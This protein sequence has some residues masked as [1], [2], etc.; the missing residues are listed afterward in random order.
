M[1]KRL[2]LSASLAFLVLL[3]IPAL[4]GFSGTDLILPAAGR[5]LG[6]G[7]S[8]FLTTGWVTNPNAEAV[9]VQFQFLEAGQANPN[10]VTVTDTLSPGQTKTYENLAE[11][12]FNRVGVLGAVRV[13]SS[14]RIL[15]S[16]R[17][18]SQAPGA[19]L[20]DTN[21]VY[22]AAVPSSFAIGQDELG[23]LQGVTNNDDF[24]YN[25]FVVEVSG[26][27]T[28]LEVRLRD[29]A[30]AELAT[31]TYPLRPW[32]QMLVST[33]DLA[34]GIM[35]D[36]GRIDATVVSDQGRAI[37]AGS[38]VANGSQD[39]TGFEM[40]FKS[41][42]LAENSQRVISLNGLSGV[43]SADGQFRRHDHTIGQQHQYRCDGCGRA[44]GT[45]GANGTEGLAGSRRT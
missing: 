10:P 41:D 43:V 39:S 24:R 29:G 13:R 22:F 8:E 33:S 42:L 12:L 20:A 1:R 5:V 25:F 7:G 18:Y 19:M 23:S 44:N 28:L 9:D 32:E 40:S 6:G 34:P 2:I 26:A 27:Q 45:G 30:G 36:G 4:A 11:T 21:G 14:A 31:K 38:L 3:A 15:A 16:A 35:V 17:I 37:F